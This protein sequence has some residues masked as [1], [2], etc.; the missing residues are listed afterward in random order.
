MLSLGAFHLSSGRLSFER[1]ILETS[2][3]AITEY[4]RNSKKSDPEKFQKTEA[5]FTR[6]DE[7]LEKVEAHVLF[8]FPFP[9]HLP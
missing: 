5:A 8:A 1:G 4:A 7:A 6:L 9:L 2:M 3:E